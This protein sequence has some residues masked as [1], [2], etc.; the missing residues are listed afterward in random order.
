MMATLRHPCIVEFIGA[1]IYDSL[2]WVAMEYMDGGSLTDIIAV[3][4]M[5]EPQIAA[6]CKE[7]LRALFE[8]HSR[9]RIHRD[10]KS[11]NILLTSKGDVK[12]ADFGYTAQLT[13]A[14]SKR[15]SVVGTP[16]WMAPELIR[17]MDYGTSVDIWSLGILAIEM[18]EGEPPYIEFPPLRALFLIATQ[19][20]PALKEA[21]K[22]SGTFKDFLARC[23]D[24]DFQARGTAEELLCHPFLRMSCPLKNLTPL[25]RKAQEALATAH[26]S[27][28]SSDSD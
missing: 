17:S 5:T 20:T 9:N 26:S 15:N 12:L 7:C 2:L 24:V 21:D 6:V 8:I 10:I 16:Y 13:E 11:D 28:E 25:L 18:A 22:W 3:C 14:V 19:G 23:L 4:K 27:D 1:W